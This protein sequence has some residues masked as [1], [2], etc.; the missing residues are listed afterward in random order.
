[1]IEYLQYFFNLAHIFNVRP[2]SMSGRA[3][4]ILAV[5]FGTFIALGILANIKKERAKSGLDAKGW[6][7][8]FY[9]GSTVGSLGF[10]YIFF[11]V[12]GVTLLA[13]RFW[14]IIIGLVA[15]VWLG[16]IIKYIK[17]ELPK[18]KEANKKQKEYQKY[19]P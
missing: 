8:I 1:M 14:L 10:V 16:F 6:K 4:I 11:A 12:Q 7:Q 18:K 15:V 19:I 9:L 3:A 17:L 13:A 2:P 5:I